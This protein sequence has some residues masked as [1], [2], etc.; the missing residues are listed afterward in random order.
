MHC[1]FSICAFEFS[2]I[3]STPSSSIMAWRVCNSTS[4]IVT[5][6]TECGSSSLLNTSFSLSLSL[7]LFHSHFSLSPSQH[8]RLVR[9]RESILNGLHE[10]PRE[11][12]G[13][14]SPIRVGRFSAPHFSLY[15]T[16]SW[17]SMCIQMRDSV[18][19][20]WRVCL[21]KVGMYLWNF[22]NVE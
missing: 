1:T 7:P 15:F 20:V 21:R 8:S 19:S 6:H 9:E 22:V 4:F 17:G 11:R 16:L 10:I 14:V 18:S 5:R 12:A 3:S 13:S 2:F